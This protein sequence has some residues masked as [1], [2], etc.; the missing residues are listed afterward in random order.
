LST[1]TDAVTQANREIYDTLS[2]GLSEEMLSKHN[3][4]AGGDISRGFDLYAES[5]FVKYLSSF[6]KIESEESGSIGSGDCTIILDPLD[7]SSNLLSSLPYYGT[8]VAMIDSDGMLDTA[9]VCNLANSD[10]F[11]KESGK[12][13][14]KGSLSSDIRLEVKANSYS[15]T[16]IFERSYLAPEISSK[17]KDSS[18]KYRSLG[19]VAL[20]LAYAH[21]VK[22]F[23][24][25]G[26]I[27]MYDVAAGLSFCEDLTVIVEDEYVIV[28]QNKEIAL[29]IE[30]IVKG[31]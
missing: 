4:G 7:G 12:A 18:L 17:L 10:I 9:I 22:F 11:I 31:S 26:P 25:L 13:L 6:G 15:D 24:L 29:K 5:I 1:F 2:T 21:S 16:G 14:L 28:S 23:L 19:A 3:I 8:S 27:R 30:T 20:S